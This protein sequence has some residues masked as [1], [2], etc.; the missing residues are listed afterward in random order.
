MF[1]VNFDGNTV[2]IRTVG[3]NSNLTL[4]ENFDGHT[5]LD[6]IGD[7]LRSSTRRRL[8]TYKAKTL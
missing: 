3:F 1:S 4:Y 7:A 2:Y 5:S 8:F 6:I